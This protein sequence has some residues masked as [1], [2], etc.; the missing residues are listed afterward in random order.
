MRKK[1]AGMLTLVLV[2]IAMIGCGMKNTA[3]GS[4]TEGEKASVTPSSAEGEKLSETPTPSEAAAELEEDRFSLYLSLLMK[5]QDEINPILGE[6]PEKTEDEAFDYKK[7]N[8]RV[9]FERGDASQIWT[10]DKTI[11]FNGAHVGDAIEKFKE[12]F[13]EPSQDVN[14]EAH[15]GYEGYFLV[16]QYDTS[17]KETMSVHILSEDYGYNEDGSAAK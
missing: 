1:I 3:V 6:E 14:G 9:W 11:D 8:I 16:V 4:N 7:A 15:F 10:I 17:T 5:H 12:V 2:M 13:G